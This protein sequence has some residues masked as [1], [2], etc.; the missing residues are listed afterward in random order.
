MSTAQKIGWGVMTL[1]AF[2]IGLV[3]LYLLTLGY[4]A[5]FSH[6]LHHVDFYRTAAEA[7]FFFGA[8]AL[9]VGPFQF[10]KSLR[11]KYINAHRTMGKLYMVSCLVAGL[12]GL[13]MATNANGDIWVKLGFGLMAVFWLVV[14]TQAYLK[15]KAK[16]IN[17]HRRWMVRSY[18]LTLAAVSL[19]VQ[20]GI[21]LGVAGLSFETTYLIVAWACWVPNLFLAQ[22]FLSKPLKPALA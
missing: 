8:I 4:E 10:L 1:L 3:P 9:L 21:W 19:R 18:A 16:D 7:H 5:G 12:A 22:W 14:T 11:Q 20:M 13:I 6:M 17:A 2:S 15:I